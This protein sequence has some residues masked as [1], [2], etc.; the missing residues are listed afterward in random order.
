MRDFLFEDTTPKTRIQ[1]IGSLNSLKTFLKEGTINFFKT[2]REKAVLI[3]STLIGKGDFSVSD[4]PTK[5]YQKFEPYVR[6][7][8]KDIS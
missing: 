8:N 4:L 6:N 3:I 1:I 5:S 7:R 2:G